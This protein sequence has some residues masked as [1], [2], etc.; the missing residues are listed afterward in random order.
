MN[1]ADI[2]DRLHAEFDAAGIPW[3][4]EVRLDK[5]TRIDMLALIDGVLTAIE[6]K[7]G[8]DTTKRLQRQF[9]AADYR[10]RQVLVVT[11]P[12]HV[13]SAKAVVGPRCGI[14]VCEE[15][16]RGFFLRRNSRAFGTRKPRPAAEAHPARLTVLLR[17]SELA[18]AL[19][20]PPDADARKGE[21]DQRL[22]GNLA[23]EQ[24][25][26]IFIDALRGRKLAA[27]QPHLASAAG[28]GLSPRPRPA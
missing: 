23:Q 15:Q 6:I 7:S 12:R 14:W 4:D 26:A 5:A 10:F 13:A 11:E 9:A 28:T 22:R 25:E 20:L 21:L 27:G 3:V 24:I 16:P 19:G 2:R 17:R 8:K 18:A 1:D